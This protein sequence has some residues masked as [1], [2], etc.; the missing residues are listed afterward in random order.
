MPREGAGGRRV[1]AG[2]DF[3]GLGVVFYEVGG[4]GALFWGETKPDIIVAIA[5]NEPPP[6]A[7]FAPKAPAEFEWIVLKALR[8]DVEERYQTIKELESDLK[9]LKQRIE[10][11]T[12]LERSMGPERYSSSFTGTA[13]TEI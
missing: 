11:Q 12:E 4:G 3:W 8:K 7:R 10:F 13:E 2:P 5:R 1:D 9:K 6:I